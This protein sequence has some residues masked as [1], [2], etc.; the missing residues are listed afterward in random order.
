MRQ[1]P[2][3]IINWVQYLGPPG[4]GRFLP[5]FT[6]FSDF[7]GRLQ[8]S[9][10][11][12]QKTRVLLRIPVADSSCEVPQ[13]RARN[14]GRPRSACRCGSASPRPACQPS[15]PR[16][17]CGSASPRAACGP[18]GLAPAAPGAG[19]EACARGAR[20]ISYR[21]NTEICFHRGQANLQDDSCDTSLDSSWKLACP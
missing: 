11:T 9:K 17:A 1:Y 5:I 21:K 10:T 4:P 7:L 6:D 2:V 15:R 14:S 18:S 19:A 12:I 8:P 20:L 16:A 3:V 13:S